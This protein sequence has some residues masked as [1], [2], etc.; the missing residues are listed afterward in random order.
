M[1]EFPSRIKLNVPVIQLYY[2]R[3]F[4][5]LQKKLLTFPARSVSLS[6]G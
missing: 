2:T 3:L 4:Q 1:A 6:I 5:Q